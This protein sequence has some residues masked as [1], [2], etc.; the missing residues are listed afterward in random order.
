MGRAHRRPR[1][2]ARRRLRAGVR[3]PR[4]G[5]G[6]HH[7][8]S[9]RPDL[10]LRCRPPARRDRARPA[11]TPPPP[12]APTRRATA[13]SPG[14]ARGGPGCRG[15]RPGPTSWWWPPRW[16]CPTCPSLDDD[17]RDELAAM[18]V[19][20]LGRLD[21]LFDEPMPYMLW[22]HQRPTDGGRLARRLGAP[23]HRPDLPLG[24]HPAL[25]GRRRAGQP[26]VLQ[27]GRPRRGRRRAARMPDHRS[28]ARW[29]DRPGPRSRPGEPDRRPHRLRAGAW[30]CPWPSTWAR[31]SPAVAIPDRVALRSEGFPGDGAVRSRRRLAD[32]A[33]GRAGLGS[34]RGRGRVRAAARRSASTARSPPPSRWAPGLSSSAA[35]ELAVAL[36]V[37]AEGS[38]AGAGP[39][40][41]AGGAAGLGRAVRGDGS[42]HLGRRGR[43]PRPAD[44]LPRRS[45]S[46]RCPCPRA[47]TVVVVHSGQ[48]RELATSAYAERRAPARGGRAR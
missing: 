12:S 20:V 39:G 46:R 9:P 2:P 5:G 48:Q 26:G 14:T 19:D 23:P 3:E 36:A 13:S 6:R 40:L 42:A 31:R 24:R 10:R 47:P 1:R 18:L 25:R 28:G 4:A 17:G 34:L 7:R 16:P 43:G 21:R 44:R 29:T 22:F 38:A 45:T 35:L 41:P 8:P 32:P 27:P 33:R 37:G 15:P 11:A 30:P